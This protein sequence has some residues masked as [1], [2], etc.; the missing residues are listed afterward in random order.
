VLADLDGRYWSA[1]VVASFTGRVVGMFAAR[2]TARFLVFS[3]HGVEPGLPD[4]AG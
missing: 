1:E 2:G 4:R 3:Y